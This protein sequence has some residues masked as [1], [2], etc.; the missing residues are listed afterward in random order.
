M[1]SSSTQSHRKGQGHYLI[2]K[3]EPAVD[4][5]DRS[6]Q[7]TPR[8][9]L[10]K[11]P[12]PQKRSRPL[13]DTENEPGVDVSKLG[14]EPGPLFKQPVPQKRQIL[15]GDVENNSITPS[16]KLLIRFNEDESNT[17]DIA[18]KVKEQTNRIEDNILTDGRGNVI[19]DSEA[20]RYVCTY[21]I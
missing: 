3:N 10:F 2:Q 17:T 7:I 11:H 8:K 18:R 15:L 5:S 20:T 21:G 9:E 19:Y 4:M 1:N 13:S 14:C 16:Q 6:N 12:V